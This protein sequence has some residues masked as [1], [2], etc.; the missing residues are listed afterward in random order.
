MLSWPNPM[1]LCKQYWVLA[2]NKAKLPTFLEKVAPSAENM[3]S[4]S[5]CIIDAMNIV[6]KQSYF[7]KA[8]NVANMFYKGIW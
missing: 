7:D 6:Q 1:I 2:K 5:P 4:Q 8:F 3:L